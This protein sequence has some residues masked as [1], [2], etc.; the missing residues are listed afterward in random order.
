M[1][2]TKLD[3]GLATSEVGRLEQ[4]LRQLKKQRDFHKHLFTYLVFNAIIWGAWELI[5]AT[6]H[7]AYPWPVWLTLGWGI[8]LVFNAWDAYFRRPIAEGEIRREMDRLGHQH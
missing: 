4:V 5:T 7:D 8:G 6:S 3:A 2:D 1:T